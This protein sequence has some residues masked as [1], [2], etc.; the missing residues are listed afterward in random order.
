MDNFLLGAR[1]INHKYIV[2]GTYE[3]EKKNEQKM[4]KLWPVS[5]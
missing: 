1:N 2:A 4:R 5:S 3:K